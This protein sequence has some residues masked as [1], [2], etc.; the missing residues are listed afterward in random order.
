MTANRTAFVAT[1][2]HG[3]F[4][5]GF[6][7]FLAFLV[8]GLGDVLLPFV[9]GIAIAY[10]LNPVVER[11]SRLKMPR[12]AAVS[13][14]L[15]C[16][17]L[18]VLAILALIVPRMVTQ[19]ADF[20]VAV[21]GYI[22][23]ARDYIQPRLHALLSHMSEED[24]AKLRDAVSGYAGQAAKAGLSV[25]AG[26]WSGGAAVVNVLSLLFI[27]PVVAFYLMRDWPE[28]IRRVDGLLPRKYAAVIREQI[29]AM[30]ATLAA[31]IRGQIS[32][33]L[34]LASYYSVALTLLGVNFGLVIGLV[35]GLL[36]F[37]P[38]V[39]STFGLV[40]AVLVALVQFDGYTQAAIVA[41]VFMFAQFMEGN[42]ISPK[43]IGESVGLHPVWIIFALMAGGALMGFLG[44]L[45]AIPV[46]AVLGVMVRFAA[47]QYLASS[48]Y[49]ATHTRRTRKLRPL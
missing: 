6:L 44:M 22:D 43:L 29:G 18:V 9:L 3:L 36:S 1:S 38:F 14:V 26:I 48:Y 28:L 13:L 8:W 12:A 42:V 27:T 34:I 15:L 20:A 21:P 31:F 5:A 30:D 19:L 45:I 17:A 24:Y 35:A 47:S 41:G 32:V 39:G 49:G 40:A 4:W 10:L 7:V 33:C 25:L 46:A 2:R 11:L 16:F 37:I 23:R